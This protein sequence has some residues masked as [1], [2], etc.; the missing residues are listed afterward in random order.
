VNALTNPEATMRKAVLKTVWTVPVLMLTVAGCAAS[1]ANHPAASGGS[2]SAKGHGLAVS[3]TSL[4]KVLSENG[5]TL[6]VLSADRTDHSTCS[7]SCLTFWPPVSGRKPAHAPGVTGMIGT[8]GVKT[9]GTTLT[10]DGRPLYTFVKDSKPG[11]VKG[12]G[13]NEFGGVWHAVSPAGRPIRAGSTGSS[14]GSSGSG[15]GYGK[16]GGG[17]Y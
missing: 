8:T 14:K 10:V 7:S 5:R 11:D 16:S 15:G 2:G 17:G 12:E 3:K 13:L 1:A 6:Y 4:G 9:G